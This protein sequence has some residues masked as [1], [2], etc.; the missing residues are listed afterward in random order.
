MYVL[1]EQMPKSCSYHIALAWK[2]IKI[3]TKLS[4]IAHLQCSKV[5][6]ATSAMAA[7]DIWTDFDWNIRLQLLCADQDHARRVRMASE[8]FARCFLKLTHHFVASIAML[9]RL[10]TL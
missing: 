4:T 8:A 7:E 6:V 9:T 2:K 3:W 1:M 5:K 10:S